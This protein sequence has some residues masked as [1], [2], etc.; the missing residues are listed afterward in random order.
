MGTIVDVELGA[1][2]GRRYY[3]VRFSDGD[4]VHLDEITAARLALGL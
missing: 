2:T 4:L 1:A 3:R